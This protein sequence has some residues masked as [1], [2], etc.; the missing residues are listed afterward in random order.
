M[1][2]ITRN[3]P[4]FPTFGKELHYTPQCSLFFDIETT[5]LSHT[6]SVLYMIGAVCF[7]GTNW[8]LHQWLA[9]EPSEEPE[10]L[11]SFLN[12]SAGYERLIH[13]NG[14]TFD[15]PFLEKKCSRYHLPD[16]LSQKESLD[17]YQIFRPL[18]RLLGLE[19]M[20]QVSL[21]SWLGQKRT[22]T[23]D[24][25]ALIPV[26][27]KFASKAAPE[28]SEPLLLHNSEDLLGMTQLLCLSAYLELLE[29]TVQMTGC[30]R[31]EGEKGSSAVFSFV[32]ADALPQSIRCL[33]QDTFLLEADGVKGKITIPLLQGQ[34]FYFFPNY[35]DYYYLPLEDQ[36]VHKS[37]ASF[38]DR[39]HR[40]AAKPSNCYTKKQGLFLPQPEEYFTPAFRISFESKQLY[41]EYDQRWEGAPGILLEY[42]RAILRLY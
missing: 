5:G 22:D 15:L 30:R 41:F 9:E 10:I 33:I 11:S 20:N 16:T 34:L 32:L 4:P 29:G 3:I 19:H 37:V 23:L 28:L 21:Q 7:D 24:G 17:L 38:V 12:F 26:Y 40:Q 13:F 25:K 35:R 18:K 14:T 1:I 27:K 6:S 31:M 36:A 8:T 2:K 42:V 39:K